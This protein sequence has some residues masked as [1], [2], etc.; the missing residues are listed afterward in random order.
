MAVATTAKQKQSTKAKILACC[1]D[2][3]NE[4]GP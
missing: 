3:F 4:R 1:R 2:L